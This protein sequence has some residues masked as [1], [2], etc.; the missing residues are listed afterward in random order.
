MT[1]YIVHYTTNNTS[2]NKELW[3][4]LKDLLSTFVSFEE[5]NR[6]VKMLKSSYPELDF[7]LKSLGD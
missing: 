2:Q 6:R 1:H 5:G 4:S 3:E 7:E